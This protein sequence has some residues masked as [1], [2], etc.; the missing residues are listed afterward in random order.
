MSDSLVGT[1]LVGKIL[2]KEYKC[3]QNCDS[4]TKLSNNLRM[5]AM[6]KKINLK[7]IHPRMGN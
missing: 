7:T 4:V 5:R 6:C 2:C 1:I 3:E